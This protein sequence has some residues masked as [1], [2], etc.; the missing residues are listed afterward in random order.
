[1]SEQPV[2]PCVICRKATP[3]AGMVCDGDR[4]WLHRT[5]G[6]IPTLHA[7]LRDALVPGQAQGQRV[8]GS[9]EAPLPLRVDALDL[10]MP[11]RLPE[12]TDAARAH[13]EDQI[14]SLSVASVLDSWVR[15]WREVR[16][17][18]EIAPVPTVVTLARWLRDRLD[19]ACTNHS[20]VD[21]FAHEM[22]SL[23]RALRAA[24]G[25]EEVRPELLDAP[26]S[27]CDTRAMYRLPGEDRVECGGCGRR[28][29]E[30]EYRRW[31]GL[32]AADLREDAA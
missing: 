21:E 25:V 20:A 28:L 11:A 14:G 8:S 16:N 18:R 1:M 32:L 17:M 3:T 19:W 9:R 29:T 4:L 5:L 26:C 31:C 30:D 13:P 22:R 2:Y 15:D 6:E 7:R 23:L 10:G 24:C 12:P 27:R